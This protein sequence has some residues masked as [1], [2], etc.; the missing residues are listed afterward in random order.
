MNFVSSP[1]GKISKIAMQE[2]LEIIHS[3]EVLKSSM[4]HGGSSGYC[5]FVFRE[6][7]NEAKIFFTFYD[8]MSALSITS[9]GNGYSIQRRL[10]SVCAIAKSLDLLSKS[11]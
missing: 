1:S 7:S 2:E 8:M 6:T 10:Q 11:Y 9:F 5:N 4:D 3:A